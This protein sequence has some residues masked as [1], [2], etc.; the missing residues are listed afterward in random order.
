M[1]WVVETATYG[2]I[3]TVHPCIAYGIGAPQNQLSKEWAIFLVQAI[4]Y[5][6]QWPR[7]HLRVLKAHAIIIPRLR[8]LYDAVITY[9]SL[10][11]DGD[12][13]FV[14]VGKPTIGNTLA[15]TT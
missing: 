15:D 7:A 13:R 10:R 5:Y 6:F 8:R 4:G 1:V 14:L 11:R 2:E 9:C 12:G 3:V